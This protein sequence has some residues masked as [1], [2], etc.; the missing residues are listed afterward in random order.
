MVFLNIKQFSGIMQ[1]LVTGGT[2]FI[3]S[4]L[5]DDLL[6]QGHTIRVLRRST[7]MPYHKEGKNIQ[8]VI[9]DLR[10]KESLAHACHHI[11]IVFHVA[12]IPR[13]W[14]P[15][16]T[17]FEVNLHGT[18][19]LLD[20][21]VKNNVTRFVFMSS[22][23][24]YGFPK[25]DE[26]IKED[27]QKAPT[28]KYGE[29]KLDAEHLLESYKKKY[30]IVVSAVRSPLVIG[31]RDFLITPFLI[32]TLRQKRM[33]YIGTGEQ[34]LS[35]SDGRDVA[36]CLRLC[37][38]SDSANGQV[39]NVKS[40][41]TTPKQLLE[42][43]AEKLHVPFPEKHISYSYA[44]VLASIIEGIWVLRRKPNPPFTRHKVKI[45][46]HTRL[47]DITKAERDLNYKS[48]YTMDTTL[49]D[50]IAWYRK[51]PQLPDR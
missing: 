41:D 42:A 32:Q 24:V 12:A 19:N 21:C 27:Y 17:F 37:G 2:G 8:F 7:S 29:S 4:H 18:K 14:G 36:T 11:D 16:K 6:T 40:F 10:D 30:G 44:Y 35:V 33:F 13:D 47:L 23:A 50:L 38:E 34:R 5:I 49:N 9:G 46:S 28:A 1:V 3:G 48:K 43:L 45:L 51:Q 31:P 15:K 26:P 20:A 25:T 39:Y 22:A